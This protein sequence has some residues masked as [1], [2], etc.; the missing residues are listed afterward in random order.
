M[1]GLSLRQIP[2]GRPGAGVKVARLHY[3]ADPTM[4]PERV[5]ALRSQYTSDARWRREMEIQY[6]ALEGQLLY[7]EWNREMNVCGPFDVSDPGEWTIWHA[8]DPHGRTP[9]AFVW[10][11][12]N[13][14][15]DRVVCGELWSGR[16]SSEHFT[17][18]QYAHVLK[19]IESD[20]T[21]KPRE[22]EWSSGKKLTVYYRVMDT[23]GAAVNS[24]E[25]RDFF[26]TYRKHGFIYRRALKGEVRLAVARDAIANLLLPVEITIG[27]STSTRGK[28]RVFEGCD[29][30]ID[31]FERVRYPEGNPERPA[32]ERPM[33]YRKHCLDCLHYIETTRPRFVLPKWLR[34]GSTFEIINEGVGW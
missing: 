26:E 16:F 1:R 6:E 32:D 3:L 25:G 18:A 12:I 7:P 5:A 30:T 4:T 14:H 29:E 31:E 23:H 27:S 2:E 10:E 8:C 24:D 22:F 15:G 11:A 9:H 20:S 21:D 28:L 19:L 34:R 33:T 13:K 17:V